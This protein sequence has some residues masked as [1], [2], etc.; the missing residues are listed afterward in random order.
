MK[1]L[2][3]TADGCSLVEG[4]A[5]CGWT[6]QHLSHVLSCVYRR[7]GIKDQGDYWT[8]K[9]RR[10]AAIKICKANGWWPEEGS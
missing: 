9:E 7:L 2:R 3:A 6:S 10:Q 8:R 4:A 1:A 5:R